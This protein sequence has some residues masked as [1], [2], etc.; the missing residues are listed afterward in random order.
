[1]KNLG[2]KI[3]SFLHQNYDDCDQVTVCFRQFKHEI[4]HK[5]SSEATYI[6]KIKEFK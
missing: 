6:V 3:M 5:E 4:G 2:F 1:M